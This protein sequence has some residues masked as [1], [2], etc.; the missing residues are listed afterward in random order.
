MIPKPGKML[1]IENLRPISLTSC[2]GKPYERIV[3]KRIQPHL[4]NKRLYTD[5]MFGV[6]ANLSTQDLLL[7]LKAVLE[8][9]P[10][11]EKN[12]VM[13]LDIKGAFDNAKADKQAIGL[14]HRAVEE[15]IL[16]PKSALDAQH[17][18][19][20]VQLL[21]AKVKSLED[22][23]RRQKLEMDSVVKLN[24][25]LQEAMLI[26]IF[27]AEVVPVAE[28]ANFDVLR[29]SQ[30]NEALLVDTAPAPAIASFHRS[31]ETSMVPE[32]AVALGTPAHVDAATN[33]VSCH[34]PV[35]TSLVMNEAMAWYTPA[36]ALEACQSHTH[37]E[38]PADSSIKLAG[39]PC[40][41]C[42]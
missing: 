32:Q 2:Q 11:Q 1:Q 20:K 12:V 3:T 34:L 37:D 21:E 26:K 28:E 42:Q 24:R 18:Q 19:D 41:S 35:E 13:A 8:T 29:D 10:K 39:C 22:K 27:R 16:F 38:L 5:I 36:H 31:S 25:Q 33:K 4:E 6:R 17:M 30:G 40:Y 23:L 14:A 9:M 7:Q 15:E